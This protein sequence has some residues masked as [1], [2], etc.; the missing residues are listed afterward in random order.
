MSLAK[1]TSQSG[2]TLVLGLGLPWR[3][4]WK[5]VS[6]LVWTVPTTGSLVVSGAYMGLICMLRLLGDD[7]RI[8]LGDRAG[9]AVCI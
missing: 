8:Y 6:G 5:D 7:V 9:R 4:G 1:G 2:Q 3:D